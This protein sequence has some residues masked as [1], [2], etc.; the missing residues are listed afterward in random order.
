MFIIAAQPLASFVHPKSD[1]CCLYLCWTVPLCAVCVCDSI[2]AALTIAI[3]PGFS[4]HIA[5][6]EL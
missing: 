3:S 6:A 2:A 4:S 1:C 5:C